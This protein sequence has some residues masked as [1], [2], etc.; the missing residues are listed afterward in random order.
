MKKF[1]VLSV[2]LPLSIFA[3]VSVGPGDYYTVDAFGSSFSPK[4]VSICRTPT[5]EEMQGE[6]GGRGYYSEKSS[7]YFQ[8]YLNK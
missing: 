8:N 3:N 5:K 6:T 7:N 4:N 1:I 2:L